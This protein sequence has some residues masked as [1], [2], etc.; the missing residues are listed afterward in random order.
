MEDAIILVGHGTYDPATAQYAML[1][2][3]FK[4]EGHDKFFV[5]T[6]EGYPTFQDAEVR[7]KASGAKKVLLMPLMFVAGDHA[8]NDIAGD[9]KEKLEEKGYKVKVLLKGLGENSDIQN[10][11]IDHIQFSLEHK[12]IDII[13]KKKKYATSDDEAGHGH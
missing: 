2:Y 5:T 3:M 7:V 12:M 1:D 9:M 10:L 11:F 4:S 8:K 13:E 6:V